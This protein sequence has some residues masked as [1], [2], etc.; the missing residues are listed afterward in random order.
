MHFVLKV[1]EHLWVVLGLGNHGRE[2]LL[3]FSV[4][5]MPTVLPLRNTGQGPDQCY[6]SGN[7]N[8]G[9]RLHSI[10]DNLCFLKIQRSIQENMV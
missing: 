1:K 9:G 5:K 4:Y 2:R 8:L 6:L 3:T 7:E 10:E